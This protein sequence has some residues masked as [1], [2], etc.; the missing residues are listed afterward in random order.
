[1][2]IGSLGGVSVVDPRTL[3]QLGTTATRVKPS[4][5]VFD[6]TYIWAIGPGVGQ[7]IL[8]GAQRVDPKNLTPPLSSGPAIEIPNAQGGCYSGNHIWVMS[9]LPNGGLVAVDPIT[10]QAVRTFQASGNGT[11]T[12]SWCVFDGVNVWAGGGAYVAKYSAVSF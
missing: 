2:W 3:A 12:R 11:T 1:M 6:G 5:I 4:N 10:V 9:N 7:G 8:G